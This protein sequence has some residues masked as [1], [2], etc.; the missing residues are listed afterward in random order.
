[1]VS[2]IVPRH[3]FPIAGTRRPRLGRALEQFPE[4]PT[5]SSKT[6][7][8][9][10]QSHNDLSCSSVALEVCR[11]ALTAFNLFSLSACE[12][13]F[14]PSS[15]TRPDVSVLQ[16]PQV[17]DLPCLREDTTPAE[18]WIDAE[19]PI[20]GPRLVRKKWRSDTSLNPSAGPQ[21]T[22]RLPPKCFHSQV[23][24]LKKKTPKKPTKPD[25]PLFLASCSNPLSYNGWP[26]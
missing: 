4:R 8:S 2:Q 15:H 24:L 9:Q 13:V 12:T 11:E 21:P 26:L 20:P 5:H 6:T 17:I 23:R 16:E 3:I 18:M 25:L 10:C 7:T 22:R 14:T 1:M 19:P